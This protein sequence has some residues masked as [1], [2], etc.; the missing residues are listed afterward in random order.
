[1]PDSSSEPR[2]RQPPASA[3]RWQAVTATLGGVLVAAAL[4][5]LAWGLVTQVETPPAVSVRLDA[6]Q[7]QPESRSFL[8][9]FTAANRGGSTAGSVLVTGELRQDGRTVETGE[10]VIDYLPANSERRG[11]LFFTRDPRGLEL[12]LKPAGYVEP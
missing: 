10:V 3:R 2:H 11:G 6:V 7:P 5:Y 4:G 1:V 9:T 8:V 12:V